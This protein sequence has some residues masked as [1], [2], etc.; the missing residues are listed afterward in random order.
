MSLAGRTL[1]DEVLIG[2]HAI[3]TGSDTGTGANTFLDD[4]VIYTFSLWMQNENAG[5]AQGMAGCPI[6]PPLEAGWD[7]ALQILILFSAAAR[8]VDLS[9]DN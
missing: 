3:L 5:N 4:G 1:V 2:S 8:L 7:Q 9:E 6:S